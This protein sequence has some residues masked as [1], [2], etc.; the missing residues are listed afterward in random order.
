MAVIMAVCGLGLRK[1]RSRQDHSIA[2]GASVL[3]FDDQGRARFAGALD[4]VATSM[5]D[6]AAIKIPTATELTT[7]DSFDITQQRGVMAPMGV[8]GESIWDP[9]GFCNDC[10]LA[11]FRQYRAAELKHGRVCMMATLGLI[12]QASGTRFNFA[13]PYESEYSLEWAPSGIGVF[14]EYGPQCAWFGVLVLLAGFVELCYW[15]QDDDAAPGDFGD[16]A[17]FGQQWYDGAESNPAIAKQ[18]EDSEL[19]HGR[20]AMFA[21]TG[22][23]VAEYFTGYTAFEQWTHAGDA[24]AKT[25][26]LTMFP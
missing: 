21:F 26:S 11:T 3:T 5:S 19:A 6:S 14:S 9:V 13:Y 20:L 2:R 12:V 23:A 25:M 22:T 17:K 15:R 10:D 24:W 4:M 1:T 16:F 8:L 7:S 18:F